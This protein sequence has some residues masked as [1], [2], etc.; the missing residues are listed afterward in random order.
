MS[1]PCHADNCDVE[2]DPSRLACLKHWRM[3]PRALQK[4]LWAEYVPGQEDRKD[5]TPEYLVV[6][7][8][9][10]VAIAVKEGHLT[11]EEADDRIQRRME[12]A[13]LMAEILPALAEQPA[14]ELEW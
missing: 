8:R 3:V 7:E 12:D 10:V 14:L 2:I 5:P 4:E 11:P 6:Q 1:H 13:G 9:C